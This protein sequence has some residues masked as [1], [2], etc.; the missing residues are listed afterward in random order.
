[1]PRKD[2]AALLSQPDFGSVV[3]QPGGRLIARGVTA[4]ML[5]A[6]AYGLPSLTPRIVGGPAWVASEGKIQLFT[7]EAVSDPG[8][9][10][11]NLSPSQLRR[12]MRPLLRRLLEER[13]NLVLRSERKEMS[14]FKLTVA[15]SGAKFTK[16][17][18]TEAQCE[19]EIAAEACHNLVGDRRRGMSG[20]A[21]SLNDVAS[22]LE[23]SSEFPIVNAT[24]MDGLFSIRTGPYSRVTTQLVPEEI[25]QLPV[26]RP[27]PAGEPYPNVLKVLNE[28]LG[29]RLVSGRAQ[30][31]TLRIESIQMP[32]EN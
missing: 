9:I 22:L 32:T 3:F 1:M 20:D 7:V 19:T 13:F 28:S 16:S 5:I 15:P 11:E 4:H 29:L 10:P 8:I 14:V 6:A 18:I 17:S 31:E 27:A 2:L 21:V 26:D 30:V 24:E 25:L 12:R 23:N